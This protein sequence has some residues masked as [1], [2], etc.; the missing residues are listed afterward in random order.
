MLVVIN[1]CVIVISQHHKNFFQDAHTA[2]DD[3]SLPTHWILMFFNFSF[4]TFHSFWKE[5]EEKNWKYFYYE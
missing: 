3:D 2:E 5:E 4:F 1:F